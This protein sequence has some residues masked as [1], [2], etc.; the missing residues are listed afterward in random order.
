MLLVVAGGITRQF[1]DLGSQV[2]EDS[3]EVN[4]TSNHVS[5]ATYT[6]PHILYDSPGAPAPTRCA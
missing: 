2:F 5:S 6:V 3:G 4:Y 1:E